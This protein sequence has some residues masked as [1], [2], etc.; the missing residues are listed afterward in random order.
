MKQKTEMK[1]GDRHR[2]HMA[3][4]MKINMMMETKMDTETKIEASLETE[5]KRM[6]STTGTKTVQR[7][8]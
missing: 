8:K 3:M 4:K 5:K 1:L 2:Q 7:Q 6:K